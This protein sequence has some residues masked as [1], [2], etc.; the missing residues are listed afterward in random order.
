MVKLCL[1]S[2]KKGHFWILLGAFWGSLFKLFYS[3]KCIPPKKNLVKFSAKLCKILFK[4]VFP[5]KGKSLLGMLRKPLVTHVY[6]TSIWVAPSSLKSTGMVKPWAY[7]KL[8]PYNELWD[9]ITFC[10]F[11]HICFVNICFENV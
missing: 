6:N 10:N 3:T 5:Q 7:M 8:E 1:F 9:S 2:R 4:G 11:V